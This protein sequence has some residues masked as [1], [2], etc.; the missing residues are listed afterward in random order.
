MASNASI[1]GSHGAAQ[2]VASLR[3]KHSTG[4][5][6]PSNS[7]TMKGITVALERITDPAQEQSDSE[8]TP[9]YEISPPCWCAAVPQHE[10]PDDHQCEVLP[11]ASATKA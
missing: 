2:R 5:S 11:D 8:A 4:R 10:V 9:V 3:R 7:N 6:I 1:V